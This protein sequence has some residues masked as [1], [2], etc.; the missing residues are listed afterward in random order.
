MGSTIDKIKHFFVVNSNNGL[1]IEEFMIPERS[2]E[3]LLSD[4]PLNIKNW[5]VAYYKYPDNKF[6]KVK[7]RHRGDNPNGWA[8]EKKN[9]PN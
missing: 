1:P 8:R 5:Q 7:I 3:N 4:F 6:R 2:K 9:I